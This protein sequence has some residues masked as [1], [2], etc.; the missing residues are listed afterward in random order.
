MLENLSRSLDLSIRAAKG[1]SIRDPDDMDKEIGLFVQDKKGPDPDK[2]DL[3]VLDD[4]YQ[5]HVHPLIE[6][7]DIRLESLSKL[8][9]NYNATSYLSQAQHTVNSSS[10][11]DTRNWGRTKRSHIAISG[12]RLGNEPKITLTRQY[13]FQD[14]TGSGNSGFDLTLSVTW[15]LGA[16]GFSFEVTAE[17]TPGPAEMGRRI[18][19]PELGGERAEMDRT[20]DEICRRIMNEIDSRSRKLN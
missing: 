6:A 14:Y 17:N 8:F 10:L 11:F 7:L 5:M 18:A 3:K 15:R 4:V 9:G 20:I 2:S 19:Y 12:F 16:S 1:E 13:R